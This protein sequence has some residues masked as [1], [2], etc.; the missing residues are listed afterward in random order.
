MEVL[1]LILG[2]GSQKNSMS[3]SRW[4]QCLL[5]LM[6]SSQV[7]SARNVV[8][9]IGES[10]NLKNPELS[11][12]PY[13]E[14]SWFYNET[15]KILTWTKGKKNKVFETNL[16][17]RIHLGADN[18]TLHIQQL[19]KEDS[20]TY[21]LQTSLLK[22]GKD[23]SEHIRLDVYER[24]TEP[25]ITLGPRIND[26]GACLVNVTCSVEQVRENVTYNWTPVGQGA[27]ASSGGPILNI[28][29]KPGDHDQY[30]CTAMNP[31]SN[32]SHTVLA[33]ELCAGKTSRV[34]QELLVVILPSV[35]SLLFALKWTQ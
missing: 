26:N 21:K 34:S 14:V 6:I 4:K 12:E 23:F 3:F 33:S 27:N 5:I 25:K 13:S 30:T 24:L 9:A 19:Q 17:T 29:W 8:G 31:V 15:Q 35:F 2:C 1:N 16:K 18:I 10:I 22:T 32:S 11:H 20:S 28:I 7:H